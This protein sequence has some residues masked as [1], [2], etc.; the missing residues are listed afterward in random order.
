L[1]LRGISNKFIGG[2]FL[3]AGTT[4]G[5]GTLALPIISSLIGLANA[6]VLI[7]L[8]WALMTYTSLVTL[9]INIPYKRGTALPIIAQDNYGRPGK[10]LAIAAILF[11]FYALLAAYISGSGSLIKTLLTSHFEVALPHALI[12]IVFLL[13][14]GGVILFAT[15]AVDYVNR[16]FF[17]L[18]LAI[19]MSMLSILGPFIDVSNLAA[20]SDIVLSSFFVCIPI[21]FTS[22]GSHG[23]IPAIINYVG[24]D[25]I[26][27]IRNVFIVGNIIPLIFYLT[28]M[29]IAMGVLP[30]AGEHS[31][32][33]VLN[34]DMDVGIFISNLSAILETPVLGSITQA[35]TLFAVI[36]SFLGVGIGL[37]ETFKELINRGDNM[38]IRSQAW[39]L[40]FFVPMQF[41][42]FYPAGFIKALGLAS[43]ALSLIAV[44]LPTM[45]AFKRRRLEA[46]EYKVAGGN[47]TLLLAAVTGVTVV[48]LEIIFG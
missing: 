24:L 44:L 29:Y 33:N 15:K 40:T 21:Y 47:I 25:D 19:F 18:K 48:I 31:F 4:I 5:A 34:N 27:R 30:A 26:K 28:W 23:S 3:V 42:F 45:I 41:V 36:T 8:M 32:H 22:F 37:F 11:L 6:I 14:F 13:V 35:F 38:L 17:I 39:L 10:Y 7:L 2:V 9:E 1:I 43:I 46:Q 16:L 20:P 12:C